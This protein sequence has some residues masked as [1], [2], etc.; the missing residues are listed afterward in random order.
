MAVSGFGVN[1]IHFL[2]HEAFRSHLAQQH[3]R[4][5]QRKDFRNETGVQVPVELQ[6]IDGEETLSVPIA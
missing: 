2:R 1:E 5:R 4:K 6:Q 3:S